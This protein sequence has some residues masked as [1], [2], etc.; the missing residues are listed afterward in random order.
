M[1]DLGVS[2][3]S[4][5]LLSFACKN[6][7]PATSGREDASASYADASDARAT[8]SPIDAVDAKRFAADLDGIAGARPS[9]SAHWQEVQ[10]LCASRFA[11]LGYAVERQAFAADGVNVIGVR[12]GKPTT[13]RF[14]SPTPP[15]FATRTTTAAKAPTLF[16][17]WTLSLLSLT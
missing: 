1:K 6:T 7:S 17:P 8:R 12:S 9:G 4:A 14:S 15:T 3:L 13:P 16:L 11:E 2:F 5:A 10:D